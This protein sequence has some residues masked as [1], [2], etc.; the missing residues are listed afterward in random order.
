M[1]QK[2]QPS[3]HQVG[4]TNAQ[5]NNPDAVI[6]DLTRLMNE[7]FAAREYNEAGRIALEITTKSKDE[8]QDA[9]TRHGVNVL[10]LDHEAFGIY[11]GQ[12]EPTY[13]VLVEGASPE[14]LVAATEFGKRHAQEMVLIARKLREG[15]VDPLS[16]MGLTITLGVE[17][18]IFEAVRIAELIIAMGFAGATFVPKANGRITVY[19]SENLGMS[20]DLFEN[21]AIGLLEELA[22]DHP[23][24]NFAVQKVILTM[25]RL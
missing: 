6:A 11:A 24:L 14:V 17:P 10:Q 1:E 16:R 25:P 4:I 2:D 3:E 9:F 13:D 15:E 21:T 23:N 8:L 22:K 7:K 20:P 18:T 19:H 12:I 5:E